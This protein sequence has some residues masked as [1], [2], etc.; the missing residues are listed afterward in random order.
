MN[1]QLTQ[2]GAATVGYS[3]GVSEGPW[4]AGE[5]VWNAMVDP[6]DEMQF[7]N[8]LSGPADSPSG[9]FSIYAEPTSSLGA[10]PTASATLGDAILGKLES[11]RHNADAMQA[12]IFKTL[13]KEEL[14]SSDL[15]KVQYQLMS[16]NLEIQT[17]SNMAHHGVEDIKTIMRGQ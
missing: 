2:V 10:H 12:E 13:G 9:A 5:G 4:S 1:P 7:Q 15:L 8:A 14:N 3:P 17:T 6:A 11:L 16:V